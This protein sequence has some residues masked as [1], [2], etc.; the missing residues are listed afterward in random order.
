MGARGAAPAAL[1]GG[2]A[3]LLAVGLDGRKLLGDDRRNEVANLP[4]RI[5]V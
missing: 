3:P 2:D 1:S 4:M 5:A